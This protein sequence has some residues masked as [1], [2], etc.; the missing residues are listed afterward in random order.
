ME[1]MPHIKALLDDLVSITKNMTV[2]RS[3]LAIAN[4]NDDDTK[5]CDNLYYEYKKI[6]DGELTY[7]ACIKS[8][9]PYNVLSNIYKWEKQDYT[10][11]Y[12]LTPDDS[13]TV[14]GL[15]TIFIRNKSISNEEGPEEE[16]LNKL[17]DVYIRQNYPMIQNE[18]KQSISGS[19]VKLY[20]N[21][22]TYRY[23]DIH[24]YE[25][26]NGDTTDLIQD[27][28][29]LGIYHKKDGS[30]ANDKIETEITIDDN[31]RVIFFDKNAKQ[32]KLYVKDNKFS[33]DGKSSFFR[34]IRYKRD[35]EYILESD[36][37]DS[38]DIYET[39]NAAATGFSKDEK[40]DFYLEQLAAVN[41]E[42][43]YIFYGGFAD[44]NY[45]ESQSYIYDSYEDDPTTGHR[46]LVKYVFDNDFGKYRLKRAT[47][48]ENL[49]VYYRRSFN[50]YYLMDD[51]SD[52]YVYVEK[53]SQVPYYY[54]KVD[55]EDYYEVSMPVYDDITG[56]FKRDE[57]GL[58]LTEKTGIYETADNLKNDLDLETSIVYSK[59]YN[60]KS[61]LIDINETFINSNGDEVNRYKLNIIT[62]NISGINVMYKTLMLFAEDSYGNPSEDNVKIVYITKEHE[63]DSYYEYYTSNKD[64]SF[65]FK[66]NKYIQDFEDEVSDRFVKN[67]RYSPYFYDYNT[68]TRNFKRKY[69]Y[70]DDTFTYINPNIDI[71]SV[72][73]LF[74]DEDIQSIWN[75]KYTITPDIEKVIMEV[76]SEYI[77][78]SY[79]PLRN[80]T[81]WTVTRYDG[82]TN[83]Y[84]RALNGLPPLDNM[85]NQPRIDRFKINE[86]Y[87]GYDVNP[88]LYDLT[89]NEVDTITSNG[90]LA[91]YMKLYPNSDYLRHLGRNRIDVCKA[92]D[93]APFEILTYGKYLNEEHLI[94]FSDA[95]KISKN[96]VIHN[97]YKP[98]MFAVNPYYGSYIAMLILVH[99]LQIC[100]AQSGDILTHNKYAD[101]E[102]VQLKLKSFGFENT[103]EHIPLVYRKNIAKNIELL[104]K[105]KG[106]DNIYDIVYK[107]FGIDDVE[108]FK[109]YFRK[110][111][112][113]DGNPNISISQVP[114]SSENVV[115][116]IINKD[117]DLDYD[118]ITNADKYWGVYEPKESVK[119]MFEEYPFNYMNSKYITLNNKFNL[120][121]LN[122]SSSYYLNYIQEM[123]SKNNIKFMIS[124][125]G[126]DHPISLKNL[127]VMLFAIQSVRFG[128]D[129]NI[130]SDIIA[131]SAILKFNLSDEVTITG[132]EA[133]EKSK[134][135]EIINK[136]YNNMS[137]RQ[138]YDTSNLSDAEKEQ[139]RNEDKLPTINET[140]K[141]WR[142]KGKATNIINNILHPPKPPIVLPNEMTDTNALD[143]ISQAYLDNL[144]IDNTLTNNNDEGSLYETILRYR[145]D[146]K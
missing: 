17:G 23:T 116:D 133:R 40:L 84:Y 48:D 82:E 16:Y 136:Y 7:A 68:I 120:S 127:I 122:F 135:I 57:N 71:Y 110:M 54:D 46:S 24:L 139:F 20:R 67:V 73:R 22:N 95:Y 146:A 86:E 107:I 5:N 4:E 29:F 145:D 134:L 43:D 33:I 39:E 108:V 34:E 66:D 130:P 141:Y 3:D 96:Y 74:S 126:F 128:F 137:N 87:I 97:Y 13:K 60:N 64:G 79:A 51:D 41:V 26:Y 58:I 38:F 89:D 98:E 36:V 124:I 12:N 45:E 114:I 25:K 47:G 53:Y 144:I 117:N 76:Y 75:N 18:N 59:Y 50:E 77:K 103:F 101:Y 143:I 21:T 11:S 61:G 118:T 10:D 132:S 49:E 31:N 112:D 129:G 99:A 8:D 27:D 138:T 85:Y 42:A 6:I 35:E 106:I 80:N 78:D 102:T 100:A 55:N 72:V 131:T 94:M 90:M 9:I 91:N 15:Q 123:L 81:D 88:Y 65:I 2:K 62:D 92:R 44:R 142:G 30:V 63:E 56:D 14:N 105:N 83:G 1:L 119:K 140:E 111:L 109:Y 52:G 113:N 28:T 115:R 37:I 69:L 32:I 121:K 125:D 19:F 70:D 93:A 104:I